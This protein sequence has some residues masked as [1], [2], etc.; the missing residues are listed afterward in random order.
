VRLK[1]PKI[2]PKNEKSVPKK[3][4]EKKLF[5]LSKIEYIRIF[6]LERFETG[7]M[8]KNAKNRQNANM[9]FEIDLAHCGGTGLVGDL[10]SRFSGPP[11][12]RSKTCSESIRTYFL[13]FFESVVQTS[14]S[15]LL[16]L[17][18]LF[19]VGGDLPSKFLIKKIEN[20]N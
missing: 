11:K 17:Y 12:R 18:N 14:G 16:S 10:R 5:F 4:F 9:P 8:V 7:K 13:E 19:W 15:C 2:E 1:K 3:N 6:C 20:S